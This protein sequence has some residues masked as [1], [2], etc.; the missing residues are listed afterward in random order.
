[1]KKKDKKMIEKVFKEFTGYWNTDDAIRYTPILFPFVEPNEKVRNAVKAL[2]CKKNKDERFRESR[3]SMEVERDYHFFLRELEHILE[4]E[5]MRYRKRFPGEKYPPRDYRDLI[6][7]LT[8]IL[9]SQQSSVTV[10][11]DI[12]ELNKQIYGECEKCPIKDICKEAFSIVTEY[13]S[14][15]LKELD[16]EVTEAEEE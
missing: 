12:N 16:F 8:P 11:I 6:L 7:M 2:Q 9:A 15:A 5:E 13:V 1:M 10:T 14:Y 4:R 3:R